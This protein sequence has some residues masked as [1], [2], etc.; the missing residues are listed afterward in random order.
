MT[1][2]MRSEKWFLYE[3][4]QDSDKA[5]PEF[6]MLLNY[7]KHHW[8]YDLTGYKRSSLMRRFQHRMQRIN[9]ATYQS[10]FKYLQSH[11]NEHLAL[12]DD[13]LI[14]VTSFFRDRHAWDY[15]AAEIIPKIIASK[16]PD[17]PIR[18]WSAGCAAGQEIY[19]FLILLAEALGIEACLQRV[20][21]F[22]TDADEAVLWQSRHGVYSSSEVSGIPPELLEKYFELTPKG[23]VFHRKLRARV[24]F[25]YHDLTQDAPILNIDLLMC[26]NVLIYFNPDVQAAILARFHAALKNTGFL[27]LGQAE[28]LMTRRHIFTTVNPKQRFYAKTLEPN[29][30]DAVPRSRVCCLKLLHSAIS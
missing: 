19:S 8:G 13:V 7:L 25:A 14:N 6:E 23:Y 27:F 5:N 28:T 15:L 9:I 24:A 17:Q 29:L 10:Y 4:V 2:Q 22:A 12:L 26:R 20:Q 18:V 11:S 1:T 21:G 16:P 30:H 3:Q